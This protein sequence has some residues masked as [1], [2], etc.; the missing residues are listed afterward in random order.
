MS[1][2][3]TTG[4]IFS[5]IS[6]QY[7][8]FTAAEKRVADYVLGHKT[9]AQ[10]MSISELANECTVAD[11]TVTRFCRQLNLKGYNAFK[12]ALA[13]AAVELGE[14]SVLEG[15]EGN[16]DPKD[17][18]QELGGKIFNAQT[19]AIRQSLMLLDSEK[20]SRAVDLLCE[21]Q[22]VYCMGQGGSMIVADAAAHLFSCVSPHFFSVADSHR[23]LVAVALLTPKDAVLFF[24]YSGSTTD[25]VPIISRARSKGAKTI[26]VTR[27][28]NSPGA[29]E[30]DI[31]IQCGSNEGPLQLAS[32]PAQ[33]AQM[34]LVDLLYNEFMRRNPE[35]ARRNQESIADALSDRHL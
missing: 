24:S 22:S 9:A 35:Q 21:A 1:K 34:F 6:N 33:M 4:N 12:L 8:H 29:M 27:F 23:Q 13:K 31:V 10:Y 2:T 14:D 18:I 19:F 5:E 3:A 28:P 16:L 15:Q 32:V 30:A 11:A 7:F 25:V 17:S 26:L 20:L